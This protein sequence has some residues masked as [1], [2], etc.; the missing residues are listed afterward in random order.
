MPTLKISDIKNA[1]LG[2]TQLSAV[3]KGSTLI[4]EEGTAGGGDGG[5]TLTDAFMKLNKGGGG[6]IRGQNPYRLRIFGVHSITDPGRQFMTQYDMM[7]GYGWQQGYDWT[8]DEQT[9]PEVPFDLVGG[10]RCGSVSQSDKYPVHARMRFKLSDG[11]VT[12][13]ATYYHRS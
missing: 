2:N 6:C 12:E 13:W 7:N 1:R 9:T 4:W 3:Y 5:L 8:P 11:T 10:M